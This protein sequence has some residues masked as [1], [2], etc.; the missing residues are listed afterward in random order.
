[1]IGSPS[2][3]SYFLLS[4]PQP[5][6]SPPKEAAPSI[7][8][9]AP[10]PLAN[11]TSAA[12]S[13]DFFRDAINTSG[14]G[15][16]TK[17]DNLAD[18]PPQQVKK[19]DILSLGLPRLSTELSDDDVRETAYEVLLASLFVSGK[20]HF[21]EEKREKKR[22][23]LKGLRTKTE[24][25]NS[26][27]QVEDGYAHILDLIRVQ[28]E[29]SESMDALTKR[30]LRCINLKMVNGQL[31]VPRISLQLLSSVG[32][33]DFP[34]ERLRVQW[35]KRQANVLEEL[36]LFST[37]LEYDM[38]ETLRIVLSKL[39]DTEDWVVSVP[40]G[41]V[42]VLTI[43]ERYNTKLSALTKKFDLE[44]ETYHWTHNY[45]FN[46]RLYEKLLCS[47]FDIL[48]D[49]ELVEE[50]DE[51]LETAKLTWPILGITEKLHGIFYAW[52]LFQKF[53]QT[54]EILLLKHASLQIKKLLLHHDIGEIE[55]YTNSFVCSEDACGGDRA[56]SLVDS[57]LLKINIWCR[58][59]LENYHTHFSK[60]C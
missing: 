49:G 29:I 59:Q 37:S 27:P 52:V 50:A 35:Q 9:Q 41:R 18:I 23:F 44:D 47:V 5:S 32:K 24:G 20:M 56:L 60:V 38:S 17:D 8:P 57:A 7:G 46:F 54:G 16:V 45:H 39:K 40:E 11:S 12:E 33:L 6:D 34:T 43:I 58:R 26:S 30:A 15:Y 48:E 53:A 13:R 2:G 19:V 51:I 28:M 42:E 25:S 3:N 21:S 14:I 1:M 31:D 55:L 22:K 36:L 10:P 4:R